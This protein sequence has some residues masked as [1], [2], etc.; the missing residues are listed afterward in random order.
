MSTYNFHGDIN[1]PA[2][3]GDHATLNIGDP[4][5]AAR[6]LRLAGELALWLKSE[7]APQDRIDAAETLRAELDRAARERCSVE[8]GLVRRCLETVTL[9]LGAGST[10]LVLAQE[11]TRLFA[12]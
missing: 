6:T 9:G 8:P 4:E 10:G 11:I 12:G 1:G 7:G 5:T 2:V 3:Y